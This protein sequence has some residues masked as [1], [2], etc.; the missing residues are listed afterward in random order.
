M[1]PATPPAWRQQHGRWPTYIDAQP[2]PHNSLHAIQHTIL[3]PV[4]HVLQH[5]PGIINP[6]PGTLQ[7]NAPITA[8]QKRAIIAGGFVFVLL[9]DTMDPCSSIEALH[10][11]SRATPSPALAYMSQYL[12]RA[13]IGSG[14]GSVFREQL[15][16]DHEGY[17]DVERG[18]GR[19]SACARAE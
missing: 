8:S 9:L 2:A 19:I 12:A 15:D 7:N 16:F 13:G 1:A 11:P 6:G 10:H 18:R 5:S 3:I 4:H 14:S 17:R